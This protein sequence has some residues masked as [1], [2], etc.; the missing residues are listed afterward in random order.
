MSLHKALSIVLYVLMGVSAIL[1][2][3]F[4]FGPVVPET[5]DTSFEEPRITQ[6]ILYWAYGLGIAAAILALVFPLINIF[7]NKKNLKRFLVVLAVAAVIIGVAYLL[8]SD[9]P[10]QVQVAE[11]ISPSTFKIVGTGLITMY[12]LAGIA[13]LMIIYSEIA[14]YFK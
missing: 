1:L 5:V 8:A 14:K 11:E 2:L 4:Y 7:T 9:K 12:L 10:I 13:I 3:L 6:T